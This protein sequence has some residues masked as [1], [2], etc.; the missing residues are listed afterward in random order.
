MSVTT[1]TTVRS[2]GDQEN[3]SYGSLRLLGD[4]E[5]THTGQ[6]TTAQATHEVTQNPTPYVATQNTRDD[7]SLEQNPSDWPTDYRRMPPQRPIQRD[8]DFGVRPAGMNTGEFVFIQV[9][10]NGVRLNGVS[11]SRITNLPRGDF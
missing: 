6:E 5:L 8:L 1:T 7:M 2:T 11:N 4:Y 3:V 9:M 10:L